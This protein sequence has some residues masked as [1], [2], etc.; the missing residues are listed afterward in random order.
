M[1]SAITPK[2]FFTRL[3]A[4]VFNYCVGPIGQLAARINHFVNIPGKFGD[5]CK[6]PGPFVIFSAIVIA[7]CTANSAIHNGAQPPMGS[8]MLK[9]A[10]ILLALFTACVAFGGT[11]AAAGALGFGHT[12][13]VVSG[14]LSSLYVLHFALSKP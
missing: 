14:C 11:A 6:A 8:I 1:T 13:A 5:L 4:A 2:E 7:S 9:Y 12:V 3:D 10:G